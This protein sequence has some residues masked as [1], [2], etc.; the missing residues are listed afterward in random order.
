[1]S[2]SDESARALA[3]SVLVL[4]NLALIQA[5]RRWARQAGEGLRWNAAFGWIAVITCALLVAILA[6]PAVGNLF[7]FAAPT[8]QLLA[9][10]AGL[11]L[12]ALGWFE[13]VKWFDARGTRPHA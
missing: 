8:P 6:I 5:N 7:A 11:G 13:A 2:G 10:G 9:V 3:F 1:M 12:I 4:S